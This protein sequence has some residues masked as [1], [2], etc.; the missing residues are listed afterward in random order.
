MIKKWFTTVG[1]LIGAM[2]FIYPF[3][4]MVMASLAPE[5]EI[6]K[7]SFLPYALTLQRYRLMF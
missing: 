6:G 2:M 7:L 5:N 3:F 4:W 1:L